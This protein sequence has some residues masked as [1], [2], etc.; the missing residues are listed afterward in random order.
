MTSVTKR[1]NRIWQFSMR[2]LMVLVIIVAWAAYQYGQ[3]EVR[4]RI[5]DRLRERGCV[6]YL[7]R[8]CPPEQ[9]KGVC[10]RCF[11]I[12]DYPQGD[13]FRLN[14]LRT[15]TGAETTERLVVFV[16]F[17]V[18]A[19]HDERDEIAQLLGDLP[20]LS[21]VVICGGGPNEHAKITYFKKQIRTSRPNVRIESLKE[22][23]ISLWE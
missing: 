20:G 2:T 8:H 16:P 4:V 19:F 21:T 15:F 17:Y 7:E 10:E 11:S 6:A 9:H 23:Q 22:L 1:R 18:V 3:V 12:A 13:S 5:T 14:S